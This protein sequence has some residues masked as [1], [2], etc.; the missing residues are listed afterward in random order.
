MATKGAC[1]SGTGN[2]EGHNA[3]LEAFQHSTSEERICTQRSSRVHANLRSSLRALTSASLGL[4][5]GTLIIYSGAV[6]K[7]CHTTSAGKELAQIHF[8]HTTNAM[9]REEVFVHME[10]LGTFE[11]GNS[12]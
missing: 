2:S 12:N 4:Q 7:K 9:N 3:S 6:R 1:K 10:K 8:R 5:K 11:I